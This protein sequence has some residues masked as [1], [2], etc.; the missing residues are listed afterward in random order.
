[1]SKKL[2]CAYIHTYMHK[3]LLGTH[4]QVTV[5]YWTQGRIDYRDTGIYIR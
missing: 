4:D 1:M 5:N 2:A 3:C